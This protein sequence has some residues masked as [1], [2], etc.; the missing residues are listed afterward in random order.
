MLHPSSVVTMIAFSLVLI[1]LISSTAALRVGAAQLTSL[2]NSTPQATILTNAA[3]FVK[4]ASAS[5]AGLI[6]FPEFALI[7]DFNFLSCQSP[8]D[9]EPYSEPIGPAGTRVECLTSLFTPLQHIGCLVPTKF[10]SYNTVEKDGSNYYNTQVV[11]FNYTIVARYRKFHV[12]YTKCFTSPKLELVT[13]NVSSVYRFG[14]FTCFD[15][16]FSDPKMDLVKM[17]VKYFSYSSA[18]PVIGHD[19]VALFS[20]LYNVSVVSANNDLGEGGVVIDGKFGAACPAS[21]GD[22]ISTYDI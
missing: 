18:I 13:F 3:K 1:L 11:T 12:F 22:C 17:G 14:I 8:S 2:S 5:H 21:M 19:A 7:G 15:I 16:L 20:G 4:M 6:V 10:I 9:L